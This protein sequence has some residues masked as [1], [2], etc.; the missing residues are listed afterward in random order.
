MDRQ[1]IVLVASLAL[2][3]VLLFLWLSATMLRPEA[4]PAGADAEERE[5]VAA[6][7]P[8]A[9]VEAA[10]EVA[11]APSATA[12]VA[13]SATAAQEP[14]ASPSPLPTATPS[15]LPS[16]SPTPL[17]LP[18]P[19]I[20]PPPT[21]T[22]IPQPEWLSYLNR[23]REQANLPPLLEN[24][25]WSAGSLLH[26]IYM[27][28]TDDIA[29]SERV[30]SGWY[31]EEG[32]QAAVNGNIAATVW[33]EATAQW[34]IDYW[35]T[36]PFHALPI[37]DPQLESVGFGFHLEESEGIVAAGTMQILD[38]IVQEAPD[39]SIYP[40]LFPRDGGQTWLRSSSLFEWP[41][42]LT[43]CPGYEYPVGAPIIAQVGT[44]RNIPLFQGSRLTY[45]GQ[46]VAH[47]AL[48]ES[49]YTN[50][51]PAEERSGRNAL[52]VRDAIVLIPFRRLELGAYTA[53]IFVDGEEIS[54]AFEVVE[55]PE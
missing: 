9:E 44:G 5:G 24:G 2:N 27:V 41:R 35:M 38:G 18:T 23:F 1:R 25:T 51:V 54:W 16:P 7:T 36:A 4:G 40:V 55:R 20:T 19:T 10:T 28:K 11:A 31:S 53:T 21:A 49:N 6:S 32:Y 26:S 46:E 34:A 12:T 13:P 14:T 42:P 22:P 33:N 3:V 47:C 17:P 29:H 43:A 45:Q 48:T 50:P 37:L 15:P 8:L 39:E 52:A 30:A